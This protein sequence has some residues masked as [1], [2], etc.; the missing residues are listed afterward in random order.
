MLSN[1]CEIRYNTASHEQ[2]IGH[3]KECDI[4]LPNL[5]MEE[6]VCKLKTNAEMIELW[7]R[8]KLVGLCACYMN[9]Y[10]SLMAYITHIAIS[11]E[12]RYKG[13]GKFLILC[14]ESRAKEKGFRVMDLEV[15]KENLVACDF[16]HKMGYVLKEDRR[17]KM[18]MQR[19]L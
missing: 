9:D 4:F 2:V 5:T 14:A 19:L 8:D 16:Y 6:Y 15:L 3:Y 7:H 13:L 11:K 17:D 1:L 12:F 18:L 10:E